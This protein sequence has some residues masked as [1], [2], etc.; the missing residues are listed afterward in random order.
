MNKGGIGVGSASIV[1]V[2]SV[3]CLTV[4]TLITFVVAG[5]EK[6]LVDAELHLVKSYYEADT[7]AEQILTEVL[8]AEDILPGNF[9]GVDVETYWDGE[10]DADIVRYSCPVTDIKTLYVELAVRH[11]SFDILDWRMRDTDEWEFDDSL[12]VWFGDDDMPGLWFGDDDEI[13]DE[14][15]EID[16]PP[17]G[18]FGIDG[19]P[20]G[21]FSD[22]D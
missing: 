15:F 11:D 3:L 5:N 9:H 12:N 17:D 7:L 6:A 8:S 21:W 2:F 22:D 4:F 20:G 16:E 19:P 10:L 18:V 13:P 14:W 1:L